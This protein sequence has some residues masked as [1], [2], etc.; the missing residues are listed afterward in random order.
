MDWRN[1]D[2]LQ[3]IL[4]YERD[5]TEAGGH[6]ELMEK[7]GLYNSKR[8][9]FNIDRIDEVNMICDVEKAYSRYTVSKWN[10]NDAIAFA[11]RM[12]E[13]RLKMKI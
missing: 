4:N 13:L 7:L 12:R 8:K 3:K 6:F 9:A 2:D 5:R 10:P 1:R 11:D